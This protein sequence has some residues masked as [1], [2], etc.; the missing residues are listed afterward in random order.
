[1]GTI[2]GYHY[3]YTFQIAAIKTNRLEMACKLHSLSEVLPPSHTWNWMEK[4]E[5][6]REQENW[7]SIPLLIVLRCKQFP[8]SKFGRECW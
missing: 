8:S 2:V 3:M 1:M 4:L 5:I 6:G 7:F